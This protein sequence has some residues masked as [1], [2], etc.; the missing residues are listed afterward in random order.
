MNQ[1]K[2]NTAKSILKHLGIKAETLPD[3]VTDA[4]SKPIPCVDLDERILSHYE[5]ES[6]PTLRTVRF[7]KDFSR[8]GAG[9]HLETTNKTFLRTAELFRQM[10]IKNYFFMLQLNN[11]LLKD[12]DPWDPDLTDEQKF[13]IL[14]ESQENIWFTLR[15]LIKIDGRRFQGNRAVLSFVWSCLNHIPTLILMPRQSGK[16]QSGDSKIMLSDGLWRRIRDIKVG[17]KVMAW[18]GTETSVTAVYPQGMQD[19]YLVKFV[20]GRTANAGPEHLWSVWDAGKGR[21]GKWRVLD[22]LSVQERML[23][24]RNNNAKNHLSIPLIE[25]D[26]VSTPKRFKIHPYII[27]VLIGDGVLSDGRMLY[28][29]PDEQLMCRVKRLLP[30]G[31]TCKFKDDKNVLISKD[32]DYDPNKHIDMKRELTELGLLYHTWDT[33]RIPEIYMSGSHGE[34][35]RLLQGLMDTDGTAEKKGNTYYSTSN[36]ELSKDVQKLAWSLGNICSIT[37]R[38]EPKYTYKGETLTGSKAFRVNIRSREPW[39]LFQDP[40]RKER[41]Q[42][43]T[44]G[45]VFNSKLAIYDIEKLPEQ[46]D[47][48]CI[49]IDHPDNLYVTD[50]YVVTHNT[51]GMQVMAFIL[52]YI[53]GRGYRSGLITLAASNR[54]QFINALKKIR[55]GLPEYMINMNY[56]DKDAGNILSYQ[57]FGQD[58]ENTFEVKVPS[59]G[60]DGAENVSRGNTFETLLYDEP[61]WTKYIENIINGAGPSTL[62]AQKNAREKGIPYFT[63][64]ATTPNSILK[65]EGKYMHEEM[66]GSTEWREVFFDCYSETQLVEKVMKASPVKTTYPKFAMQFNHLQL[67]FGHDWVKRTMDKLGLSWAKAKIDLLLMWSE[68]GKNKLFDDKTREKLNDSKVEPIWNEEIN[69]TGLFVDW[70][71]TKERLDELVND[72]TEFILMGVDTS[73]AINKDACTLVLRRMKTG[74]NI[75]VGRYPLAF[76]DDVTT[77]LR[78]MILR[79][80]N[81][82]LI[83]ERNRAAHMIE[84]LLLTLPSYGIDPFKRIFNDIYQDP[85]KYKNEYR[86]VQEVMFKFRTK[87]FYLK[88]KARFGFLTNAETRRQMYGFILEAVSNTGNGIRY[89][90][91]VDEL[92][93]LETD[94]DGRI[95]HGKKGHDDLVIAWLLSYWAIRMLKNSSLYGIPPGQSLTQIS[96]LTGSQDGENYTKDQLELFMLIKERIEQLS[97]EL[98]DSDSDMVGKRI[99]LEIRKLGE[100]IPKSLK[101]VLTI[102]E[103]ISNASAERSKRAINRRFNR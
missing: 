41:V 66:L 53:I 54:M 35:L 25:P 80:E 74:E 76:L 102:D 42:N 83:I 64:K 43:C 77:V 40:K 68:E 101:R 45:L 72:P 100:F 30:K 27:G 65:D 36:E 89:G 90:H 19:D 75:G 62:T 79:I 78:E 21:R 55:A 52:Q 93:G 9:I 28:C 6:M 73:D 51:V 34:R 81:S 88:H 95:D 91:L 14:Q 99:E 87:E 8:F 22:T 70:F 56:K 67:G 2:L 57:A 96:T 49:E 82:L 37:T 97:K 17:D 23:E 15:E 16:L 7:L 11:P 26:K 4:Y 20:D 59:G 44:R 39:N 61:A 60:E 94:M 38:D 5:D 29:K 63:A 46:Q 71:V 1:D 98:E 24:L 69:D 47:S 12:V 84:Q 48:Y 50:N 32:V 31:Y 85:I 58:K 33:K 86:D 13:M 10:G 18:D 92:I 103:I 3:F